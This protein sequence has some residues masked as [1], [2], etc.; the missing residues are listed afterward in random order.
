M[1]AVISADGS[2]MSWNHSIS[3]TLLSAHVSPEMEQE[4]E[5]GLSESGVLHSG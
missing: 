4:T 2:S 3:T 1:R 5:M